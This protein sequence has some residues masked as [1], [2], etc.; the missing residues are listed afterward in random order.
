M[1]E[2]IWKPVVGW[3]G[4][5]EVSSIGRVRSLPSVWKQKAKITGRLYTYRKK[6]QMLRPGRASNGYYTVSLG[7]YNSHCVHRLVAEAFIGPR[8]SGFDVRHK[9]GGLI[10]NRVENLEYGT[11]LDNIQDAMKHGTYRLGLIK[12]YKIHPF[13]WK[14]VRELRHAQGYTTAELGGMFGVCRMVIDRILKDNYVL[15]DY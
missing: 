4:R 15:R 7:R 14:T 5:Y 6:G 13:F 3:E 1:T 12:R 8:P 10:D 11:R 9:D 2:E